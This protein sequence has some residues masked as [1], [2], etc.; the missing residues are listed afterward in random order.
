MKK[1]FLKLLRNFILLSIPLLGA[2]FYA[3]IFPMRYHSPEY[4]MWAEEK[5]FVRTD[6]NDYSVLIIGDSRA[7]SSVLPELLGNDVYNMAIGGTTAIEMYYA[8]QNYLKANDPPSYAI[9]IFAPYHFCDIDNYSQTLYYHYLSFWEEAGLTLNAF[10][11]AKEDAILHKGWFTDSLSFRLRL[12]NK[13][14]AEILDAPS[15]G[16]TDE[17]TAV[18]QKI[19]QEKG[20]RSFGTDEENNLENYEVHHETFDSSELVVK[21]FERLLNSLEEAGTEVIIEQAPVNP[22]SHEHI[23]SDFYEGFEAWLSETENRH[24]SCTVV[25][26]VPVYPKNAFGDNNH[27]N[28]RGAE[29]YTGEL[30]EKYPEIFKGS[31]TSG[32]PQ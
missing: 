9:L 11:S 14:M 10:K 17:N 20:F 4:P 1:D 7:K 23:T 15:G 12:P 24:P 30:L 29:R 19:R 6:S 5:S 18:F 2:V 25:H 32:L 3:A 31:L 13:Y 8:F 27:L 21:Y 22:F 16:N 28:R 26:D